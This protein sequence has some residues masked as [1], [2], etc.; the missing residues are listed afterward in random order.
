M[1]PSGHGQL[2]VVF[3]LID[4]AAALFNQAPFRQDLDHQRRGGAIQVGQPADTGDVQPLATIQQEKHAVLVGGQVEAATCAAEHLIAHLVQAPDQKSGPVIQ[5]R[6]TRVGQV[7]FA[8]A[9]LRGVDE[10]QQSIGIGGGVAIN[11][12]VR[13]AC[14][15][16]GLH[17]GQRVGQLARRLGKAWQA[18]FAQE[19]LDGNVQAAERRPR[20]ALAWARRPSMATSGSFST[21]R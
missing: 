3:A 13:L 16:L 10:R 1:P 6:E 8:H 5:R 17:I 12:I 4:L 19:Q 20:S 18:E 11:A 9:V 15:Y 7:G 2:D 21:S 14:Q